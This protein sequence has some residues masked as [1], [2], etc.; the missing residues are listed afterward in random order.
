MMKKKNMIENEKIDT[1]VKVESLQWDGEERKGFD[2][3][4]IGGVMIVMDEKKE[5]KD[6]KKNQ[7]SWIFS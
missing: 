4:N 3:N 2:N 6:K 1:M 5:K 7:N